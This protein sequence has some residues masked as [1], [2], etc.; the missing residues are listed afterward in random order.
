[1]HILYYRREDKAKVRKAIAS[2]RVDPADVPESAKTLPTPITNTGVMAGG[3]GVTAPTLNQ[4]KRKAL[5]EA[6]APA[7]SSASSSHNPHSSQ[8]QPLRRLAHR[9]VIEIL[10]DEDEVEEIDEEPRDELY[11]MMTAKIVGVQ[12]YRGMVGPGE[13]VRLAREP[14]NQYDRYARVY[15]LWN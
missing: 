3:L 15:I 8:P 2:R 6:S 1:M 11:C 4:K 10:D 9:E 14:S 12:Y 7:S 5:Q 13:E